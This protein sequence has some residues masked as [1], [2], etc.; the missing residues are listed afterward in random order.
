M[1]KTLLALMLFA[2]K[3]FRGAQM[4][5]RS[6]L[7]LARLRASLM[8]VKSIE[9]F[10]LLFVSILGIGACL[11]LLLSGLVLFH[12]TLFLYAPWSNQAKLWFGLISALVYLTVAAKAFSYVFSEAQW[13]KM[14]HAQEVV[15][16]LNT[17]PSGDAFSRSGKSAY[18]ESHLQN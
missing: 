14:F 1:K 10:R 5:H 16:D 9:T 11:I 17:Q 13:L 7:D 4:P 12:A 8:Y 6:M 2:F 3:S 18:K 15:D